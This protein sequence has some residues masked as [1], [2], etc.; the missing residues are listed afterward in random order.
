MG[1]PAKALAD[2]DGIIFPQERFPRLVP[3][4]KWNLRTFLSFF[5][6]VHWNYQSSRSCFPM[7]PLSPATDSYIN[8]PPHAAQNSGCQGLSSFP[9]IRVVSNES[10]TSP[11]PPCQMGRSRLW[12]QSIFPL[13]IIRR[14]SSSIMAV[15]VAPLHGTGAVSQRCYPWD[16]E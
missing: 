5:S 9:S 15:C 1:S 3:I 7:I 10:L 11:W 16:L 8:I 2:A 6:S 13:I 12:R 4:R 14:S